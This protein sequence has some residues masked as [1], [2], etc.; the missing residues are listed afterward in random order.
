[1]ATEPFCVQVRL[2][3]QSPVRD[4]RA[5]DANQRD[6]LSTGLQ[7]IAASSEAVQARRSAIDA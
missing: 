6:A 2:N 4:R 5:T 3:G 1:M 7:A